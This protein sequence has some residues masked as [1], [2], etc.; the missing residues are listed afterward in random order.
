MTE[1]EK[2][3][4]RVLTAELH[5]LGLGLLG[6][7]QSAVKYRQFAA[8]RA[9]IV[10]ALDHLAELAA[11]LEPLDEAVASE[12]RQAV[13]ATRARVAAEHEERRQQLAAEHEARRERMRRELDQAAL[14]AGCSAMALNLDLADHQP[15][16]VWPE[17]TQVGLHIRR[18][19]ETAHAA[20][21]RQRA[22]ELAQLSSTV[23]LQAKQIAALEAAMRKRLPA[24]P[25]IDGIAKGFAMA[26]RAEREALVKRIDEHTAK[27]GELEQRPVYKF[28]GT[29]T[30][31]SSYSPGNI[32]IRGGSSWLCTATTKSTPGKSED[33]AQMARAGRDGRDTLG[34]IEERR[35]NR[36]QAERPE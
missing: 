25:L 33:W 17:N 13:A 14:R 18:E 27:I 11:A 3:R 34:A 7:L 6:V 12:G 10:A 23:E 30:E 22:D 26:L 19:I 1:A 36:A 15:A 5:K 9:T 28:V 20:P 32:A 4:H 8:E 2:E 24:E 35:R 31:G 29:F 21:L 16:L